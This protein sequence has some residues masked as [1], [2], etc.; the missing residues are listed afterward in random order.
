M[1]LKCMAASTMKEH[2]KEKSMVRSGHRE[3]ECITDSAV[4]ATPADFSPVPSE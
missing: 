2:N 3:A 4:F 1:T